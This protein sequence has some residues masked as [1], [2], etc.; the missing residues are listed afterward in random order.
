MSF[1]TICIKTMKKFHEMKK[2]NQKFTLHWKPVI[3]RM[4][5]QIDHMI[6]QRN[7][8]IKRKTQKVLN[9]FWKQTVSQSHKK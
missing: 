2:L 4:I 9:R 7:K 5:S 6:N 8:A 1:N 3:D